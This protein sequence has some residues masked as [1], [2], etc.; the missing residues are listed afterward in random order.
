MK[1][2]EI[3]E[4][5]REELEKNLRELRNKLTKIKFDIAA[6]QMKNH[7]EIRKVKKDIARILTVIKLPKA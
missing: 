6:K 2:K 3:R 5:S 1:A 4:K 7:R